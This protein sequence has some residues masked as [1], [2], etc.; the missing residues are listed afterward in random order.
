[1]WMR[2]KICVK[3]RAND[4][5]K[6][7]TTLVLATIKNQR[8]LS[9][10]GTTYRTDSSLEPE[11]MALR[12]STYVSCMTLVRC[13]LQ[14]IICLICAVFPDSGFSRNFDTSHRVK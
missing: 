10:A 2:A 6:I 14:Q 5:E 12:E 4:F 3:C 11:I 8:L 13:A 7:A 1:M 9:S